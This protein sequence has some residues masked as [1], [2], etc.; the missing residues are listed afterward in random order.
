[1]L[2]ETGT[3]MVIAFLKKSLTGYFPYVTLRNVII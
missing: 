1:M 3:N 2:A